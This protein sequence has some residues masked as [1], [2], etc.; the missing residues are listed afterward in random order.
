MPVI[1]KVFIP[2]HSE[3]QRGEGARALMLPG[4]EPLKLAS[5]SLSVSHTIAYLE[6]E[7]STGDKGKDELLEKKKKIQ[8]TV[9]SP[10]PPFRHI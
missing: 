3:M 7:F 6:E 2:L 4:Q 10:S 9:V 8:M 1:R 5:L